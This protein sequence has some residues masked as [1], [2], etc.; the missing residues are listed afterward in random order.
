MQD[1]I[2]TIRTLDCDICQKYDSIRLTQEEIKIRANT[3]DI[4]IGAY[5][6]VHTD[7]TR[8]IY[9]DENGSYLGDTIALSYDEIPENLETQP[10][11]FYIT[12]ENKRSW[13]SKI[14]KSIF[15][16]IHSKNLTIC[17]AGPSQA[18]KTSFVKYLETL[19]PERNTAPQISVPTMGKSTKRIK[20][21]RA[22]IKT[23]DM[24]GQEDFW[25]LWADSIQSSDLVIFIF[26]GT[27]TNM[28]EVAKAF[29]RVIKYKSAEIPVLIIINKK[30]L[31]L[32]GETNH[33]VSSGEFL[34]LTTLKLP[35]PNVLAIEASIFEGIAYMSSEFEEISLVEIIN[36]FFEDYC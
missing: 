32:R 25:D 21:G 33:F 35:I 4:G 2:V 6:I 31:T 15:S 16:K 3:T 8:I 17:I 1:Q 11:P 29:E 20:L 12:N 27:S 19:V 22:T 5:S 23:L 10:L 7:H 28:L 36:S 34:A 18:G 30:D 13:Y 14:R 26:D 9:F 24:G